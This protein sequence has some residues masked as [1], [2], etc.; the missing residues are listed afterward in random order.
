M[1]PARLVSEI[2]AASAPQ[3]RN[4]PPKR[5]RPGNFGLP[6][7]LLRDI[8]EGRALGDTSTL[9]DSAVVAKLKD[10]YEEKET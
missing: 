10:E 7:L 2:R 5:N 4:A 6:P 8:A 1:P 3:I 9:A